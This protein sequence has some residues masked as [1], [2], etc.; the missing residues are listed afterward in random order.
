M[1]II[2]LRN[3]YITNGMEDKWYVS[4]A[5]ESD[6][7]VYNLESVEKIAKEFSPADVHVVHVTQTPINGLSGWVKLDGGSVS[8]PRERNYV[9]QNH[10]SETSSGFSAKDWFYHIGVGSLL[11]YIVYLGVSEDELARIFW[12]ILLFWAWAAGF[13]QTANWFS[14]NAFNRQTHEYTKKIVCVFG[15][16]IWTLLFVRG[17]QSERELGRKE[18]YRLQQ[19]EM[20]D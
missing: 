7:T 1:K 16:I 2:K 4:L 6:P 18:V 8:R 13:G 15:F 11:T 10:P 19:Y 5:G 14:Q 12:N 9:P 17:C 3:W 20:Y